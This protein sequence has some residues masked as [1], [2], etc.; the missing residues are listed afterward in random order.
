MDGY[1]RHVALPFINYC[2][3]YNIILTSVPGWQE[4]HLAEKVMGT[5]TLSNSNSVNKSIFPTVLNKWY[6][7]ATPSHPGPDQDRSTKPL[8]LD[9]PD[10]FA[11]P[12]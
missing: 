1:S 11:S 6:A 7:A 2:R 12:L 8:P 3:R 9:L 10:C 5:L 4:T